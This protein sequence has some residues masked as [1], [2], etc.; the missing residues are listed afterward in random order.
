MVDCFTNKYGSTCIYINLRKV[1]GCD[2]DL[3]CSFKGAYAARD[4][5]RADCNDFCKPNHYH[6][7]PI[8][9]A[10]L[11]INE[12]NELHGIRELVRFQVG[13]WI[14]ICHANFRWQCGLH[15]YLYRL[16]RQC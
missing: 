3:N 12:C 6:R 10:H 4:S 2:D 15:N 9:N 7:R 11:V 16:W 14:T 8:S 5:S 1:H 13:E